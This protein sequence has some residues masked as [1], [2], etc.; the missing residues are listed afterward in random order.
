MWRVTLSRALGKAL[1]A[2]RKNRRPCCKP[3]R[4][5]TD[6][7]D[8]IEA[9][10]KGDTIGAFKSLVGDTQL[11]SAAGSVIASMQIVQDALAKLGIDPSKSETCG[12]RWTRSSRS[13]TTSKAASGPRPSQTSKP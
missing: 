7:P 6:L 5:A 4:R 8:V 2:I 10:A 13:S 1:A 12:L 3:Y 11:M 9:F